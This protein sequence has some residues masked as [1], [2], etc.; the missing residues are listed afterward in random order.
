MFLE[1]NI[2]HNACWF[3]MILAQYC[4]YF[5]EWEMGETEVYRRQASPPAGAHHAGIS[6]IAS[7]INNY[8]QHSV[9]S[10]LYYVVL[11]M[12]L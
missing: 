4:E 12:P 9:A 5:S 2:I 11:W 8:L 10:L 1:L 7:D 6:G 3:G